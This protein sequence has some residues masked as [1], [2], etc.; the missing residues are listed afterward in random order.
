LSNDRLDHSVWGFATWEDIDSRIDFF[1][2]YVGGL[3][4]AFRFVDVPGAFKVGDPPLKGRE[5]ADKTLQ[6]NFWRPGDNRYEHE[7]ELRFGVPIESDPAKQRAILEKYGI[8]RRL[9]YLWVYR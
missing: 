4:N 7:K 2:I 6:L 8:P 9:D 3:T 1:S 5:F